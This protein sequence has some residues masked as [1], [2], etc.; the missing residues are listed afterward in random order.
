MIS[1]KHHRIVESV[2]AH[3]LSH[4]VALADF[5]GESMA[6]MLRAGQ[7]QVVLR[8]TATYVR[9]ATLGNSLRI[10][11]DDDQ[12]GHTVL[13]LAEDQWNGRIIPDLH[14]GCSFCVVIG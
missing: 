1:N 5:H 14:H 9:D 12:A 7:R 2:D 4:R 8:G 3:T 11:L 13:V 10:E 6:V